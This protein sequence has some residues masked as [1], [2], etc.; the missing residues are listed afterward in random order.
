MIQSV[1]T[2]VLAV[3][4]TAVWSTSSCSTSNSFPRGEKGFAR[5]CR[6]GWCGRPLTQPAARAALSPQGERGGAGRAFAWRF[7]PRVLRPLFRPRA[8]RAGPP[9][10]ARGEGFCARLPLRLGRM[11][12]HPARCAG[13]PLPARGRGLALV[14]LLC[15]ASRH[16]F[17]L[18]PG[19]RDAASRHAVRD[20]DRGGSAR[21]P[22]ISALYG[23]APPPAPPRK[24][25]GSALYSAASARRLAGRRA[26]S[27]FRNWPV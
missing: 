21:G 22:S 2:D 26:R 6:C 1:I 17:A 18:G 13:D 23:V 14:A 3:L 15:G 16:E 20:D 7:A 5:T 11:T 19:S 9:S 25:E 12:P 27:S 8:E 4:L 10:P 24:G